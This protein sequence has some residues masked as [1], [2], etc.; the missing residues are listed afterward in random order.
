MGV[1]PWTR[2]HCVLKLPGEKKTNTSELGYVRL[3]NKK[4]CMELRR[5]WS[6]EWRVRWDKGVALSPGAWGS[7]SEKTSG[8]M[9]VKEL[10]AVNEGSKEMTIAL[11]LLSP[12]GRVRKTKKDE[13]EEEDEEEE[14]DEGKGGGRSEKKRKAG[15]TS[16]AGGK[17]KARKR[18]SG[19]EE[20]AS[21]AQGSG[22]EEKTELDE[23][24]MKRRLKEQLDKMTPEK[25]EKWLEEFRSGEL[26]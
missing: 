17:K 4:E 16:K 6:E 5:G 15:G 9:V 3:F 18:G 22:A 7:G 10:R 13:A 24:E 2:V 20:A 26:P 12:S 25:R 23:K 19:G 11:L 21:A 14:E 8:G 1:V